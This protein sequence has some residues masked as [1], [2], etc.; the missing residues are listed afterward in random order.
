MCRTPRG[1]YQKLAQSSDGYA[2]FGDAKHRSGLVYGQLMNIQWQT[3][4]Q[5]LIIAHCAVEEITGRRH[6]GII[7]GHAFFHNNDIFDCIIGRN[8]DSFYAN[9]AGRQTDDA[10]A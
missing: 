10:A 6:F 4:R 2:T 5:I 9:N 8:T 1:Y 3:T 7:M